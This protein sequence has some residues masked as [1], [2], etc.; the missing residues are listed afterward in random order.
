MTLNDV[1]CFYEV[2]LMEFKMKD[3]AP[4]S[5]GIIAVAALFSIVSMGVSYVV[6]DFSFVGVE[7]DSATLIT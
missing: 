1:F 3:T 4:K 6:F 5:S 7:V 2:K